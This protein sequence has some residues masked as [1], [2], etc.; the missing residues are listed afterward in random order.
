MNKFIELFES[1]T[2]RMLVKISNENYETKR[3]SRKLLE[4]GQ[5]PEKGT[6]LEFRTILVWIQEITW[7]IG[8]A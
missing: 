8:G 4:F 7:N 6:S 3:H 1:Y 5:K 2:V